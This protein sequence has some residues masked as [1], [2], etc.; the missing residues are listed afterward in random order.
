MGNPPQN[1]KNV[2]VSTIDR[3]LSPNFTNL[4]TMQN[5]SLKSALFNINLTLN[6]VPPGPLAELASPGGG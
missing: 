1:Q 3:H 5:F 2:K 6:R 4:G